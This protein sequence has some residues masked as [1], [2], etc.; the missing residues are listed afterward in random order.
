MPGRGRAAGMVERRGWVVVHPV[1]N[2]Y[3]DG[4][5]VSGCAGREHT[6]GQAE[7]VERWKGGW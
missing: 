7:V 5:P 1:Y 3:H 6:T 2:I 4:G